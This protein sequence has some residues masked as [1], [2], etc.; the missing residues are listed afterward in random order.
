MDYL[1]ATFAI[2]SIVFMFVFMFIGIWL[3]I[4]ALKSFRQ[5]RYNNFI[6]EKTY[7]KISKISDSF[8]QNEGDKV[9]SYLTGEEDFDYKDEKSD[10]KL[11]NI[12]DYN[13]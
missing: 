13:K 5:Q 6:L 4:I 10:A 9:Y 11:S 8:L 3:F 2:V 7:Q 1:F 12:T